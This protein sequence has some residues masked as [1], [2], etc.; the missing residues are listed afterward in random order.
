[1]KKHY[2]LLICLLCSILPIFSVSGYLRQMYHPWF[3]VSLVISSVASVVCLVCFIIELVLIKK[4][5]REAVGDSNK[6]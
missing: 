5:G 3:I 1:M 4:R 6:Q 2:F